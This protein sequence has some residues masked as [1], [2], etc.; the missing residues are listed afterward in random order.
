[1]FR[2]VTY[3]TYHQLSQPSH[4]LGPPPFLAGF[5]PK[6][7]LRSLLLL[8]LLLSAMFIPLDLSVAFY[9]LGLLFAPHF[10][11]AAQIPEIAQCV[12]VDLMWSTES[13]PYNVVIQNQNN[14]TIFSSS[15]NNNAFNWTV[16]Q[17]PG[18]ELTFHS[19]DSNGITNKAGPYKVVE[20][21]TGC[22]NKRNT[23]P[24]AYH[25]LRRWRGRTH[26]QRAT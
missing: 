13:P 25:A 7:T 8:S 20:G 24:P 22:V 23:Y 10:S 18:T 3:T 14:D 4:R 17:S 1:M 2:Y 15:A 21:S 11:L 6:S 5:R 19:T 12:V 16:T 26:F 9:T